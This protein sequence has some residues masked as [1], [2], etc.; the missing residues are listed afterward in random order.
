MAPTHFQRIVVSGRPKGPLVA[1][2]VFR[3][4]VV[5]YD[6]QAKE[7]EVIVQTLYVSIDAGFRSFLDEDMIYSISIGEVMRGSGVGIVREIGHGC[8][9]AVGDYVYYRPGLHMRHECL[10]NVF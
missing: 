2:E 4:E 5:P 10:F 6:L 3:L 1:S 8:N 9:V 7:G